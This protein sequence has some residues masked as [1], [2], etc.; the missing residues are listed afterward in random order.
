LPSLPVT[1]IIACYTEKRWELLLETIGS[2][3]RQQPPPAEVIVS[4]DNN[5]RLRARLEAAFT[6]VTIVE[7][8]AGRGVSNARNTGAKR[9]T[10]PYLAFVDDDA[11]TTEGWLRELLAP[12]GPPDVVGTGGQVR[13]R[14]EG[15]RPDWF[16]GEFAWVVGASYTGLPTTQTTPVR[17]VWGENMAVRAD[18]F[19]AVGGFRSGFGK[20][21]HVSRPEDTDLCIR[22]G[23]STPDGHWVY[24]PSAVVEH[25]VEAERMTFRFFLLRSYWEGLGKIELQRHLGAERNLGTEGV[26]MRQTVPAAILRN[27]GVGVRGGGGAAFA[28]AGALVAG[29]LA[30]GVGAARGL[31]HVRIGR[32]RD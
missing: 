16:P 15:G 18:V 27:V 8:S 4:V 30:A 19:W 2:V 20:I 5:P 1:V 9:A 28:R 6:G 14:W 22:M 12:F 11:P 24:T 26:W 32:G 25:A 21:G 10:T 7:N 29:M 23:A 17:N 3:L 31:A 13:P